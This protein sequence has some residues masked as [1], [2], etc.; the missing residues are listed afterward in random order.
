MLSVHQL[1]FVLFT[2]KHKKLLL[3]SLNVI[4][5]WFCIFMGY[6]G[7]LY[8]STTLSGSPHINFM[9]SMLAGAAG[10]FVYLFLPDKIGRKATLLML[11]LALGVCCIGAGILI[12]FETLPWLQTVFSMLSRVTASACVKTVALFTAELFPT[13]IR[14]SAVGMGS[15][16]GGL[17]GYVGFSLDIL[18]SIWKPLPIFIFGACCSLASI[19]ALFLPETKRTKLPETI[20]DVL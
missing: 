17:G 20:E 13:P 2:V 6:W 10:N 3:R 1:C 11:E 5:Q 9:L 19:L 18:T 16:F 4:L 14:N 8:S 12:H 15:F 7:S